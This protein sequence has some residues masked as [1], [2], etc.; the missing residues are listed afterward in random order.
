MDKMDEAAA[1]QR[2]KEAVWEWVQRALVLTVAFGFG[3]FASWIMYGSGEQGAPA[4]R[5]LTQEQ[6]D[7]IIS[8]KNDKIDIE[9]R[10]EVASG[11]LKRCETEKQKKL[12]EVADLK[13]KMLAAGLTP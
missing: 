4:L 12:T 7:Q 13:Q 11:R 5:V 1:K 6:A 9:G 2:V 10:L 8:L 3:F